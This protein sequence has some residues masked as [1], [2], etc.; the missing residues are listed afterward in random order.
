MRRSLVLSLTLLLASSGC[1]SLATGALADA[2][3]GS[4]GGLGRDDDPELVAAAAPFGLKTMESVLVSQ[5]EHLGL[6]TALAGGFVQ[7]AAAFVVMPA[8]IVATTDLPR[9]EQMRARAKKLLLR[10]RNYG[11]RGLEVEHAGVTAALRQD[12]VAALATM[13]PE[14]VPLMY[15]TA[16]AWG[17]AISTARMDTE[18]LADIPVVQAL[19]DRCLALSP[20]WGDGT[21]YELALSLELVRPGGTTERAEALFASAIAASGG[22]RAGTYV[23]LA[24][25]VTVKTQDAARFR[26]LLEKAL[27]IDVEAYPDDRLANTI[28]QHRARWLLGRVDDLFLGGD[29][30]AEEGAQQ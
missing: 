5:P 2:L 3:S 17:L 28:L 21:V 7:Y 15:W 18:L 22:R 9:A 19:A 10:G 16:A 25:G 20:E 11:L 6:L 29:E 4:G 13:E 1:A 26:A 24:E 14:D 23:S 8:D 12:P 30:P 27:A